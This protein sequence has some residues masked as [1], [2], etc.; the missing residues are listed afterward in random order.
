MSRRIAVSVRIE[1]IIGFAIVWRLTS[2]EILV[3]AVGPFVIAL[4][5]GY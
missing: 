3:V 2:D 1:R 5:Y 4:S